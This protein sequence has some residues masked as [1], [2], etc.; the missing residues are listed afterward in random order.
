MVIALITIAGGMIAEGKLDRAFRRLNLDHSTL[1]GNKDKILALMIK[2]GYIVRIKD[3]SSG[4][5]TIDYIVGPR[6]KVEVGHEGFRNFVQMM[7]GDEED[8][9]ELEKR[10]ERTLNVAEALNSSAT[11]GQA[12]PDPSQTLGRKRGRPRRGDDDEEEE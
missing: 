7:Y 4:E 5:E 12:A 11:P 1:L 10:I 3:A 9:E 2:D 8:Q 6:G